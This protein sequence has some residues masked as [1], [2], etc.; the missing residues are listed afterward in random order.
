MLTLAAPWWLALVV[1]P[2]VLERVLPAY[3]QPRRAV[4]VPF[5]D[6]LAA[7]TG[8][9]PSRGAA[10][11]EGPT[12]QRLVLWLVW[13]LIVAALA[14]PQRLEPPLTRTVP[15]RDL[16]LAVDLS[17]SMETRDFT[18]ATGARIDRLTAVKTVLDDFLTRRTGDRVGLIVFGSAPFVQVPFTDDLTTCRAL[19]D[20]VQ[21]RMAGPQTA[22]GDAIGLALD[23]FA[24]ADGPRDRVLIALTDGNDTGSAVPPVRAAE[25]AHDRGVVV[26]TVAVGDPTAAGE[27]A[28]DEATLQA[29]ATTTGGRYARANDRDALARV[30]AELDALGTRP[31]ETVSHQPRR[32]LFQW[33]LGAALV[34]V[35]AYHGAWIVRRGVR[36]RAA[37]PAALAALP[38]GTFHFLRPWWLLALVPTVAVFMAVRSLLDETRPWRG[39]IAPHLL[40]HL[41]TGRDERRGVQPAH[42]LL[43]GGVLM[44]LAVAGPAWRLEPSPFGDDAA[45]IV[46]VLE[47]TP[48]M[49]GTD[50]QPT[51]LARAAQKVRD[52]LAARPGTRAGLVAYAGSG[53]LVLPP[54]SDASLVGRFAD[55]LAPDLMPVDGDVP[56]DGLAVAQA[57]LVRAGVPG[58]IVLVT[59]GIPT[60]DE[61]RLTAWH[62]QGSAPV[63]VLAVAAGA[64]AAALERGAAT[65]G[66]DVTVVTP[67]DADVRQLARRAQARVVAAPGTAGEGARWQDAGWWLAFGVAAIALA[68]FRPGWVVAWR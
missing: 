9:T 47:V 19:L 41:L 17:G 12:V 65:L 54:T 67:D 32:D 25:I 52:L 4:V 66:A 28:L 15:T 56:S 29:V 40:S 34:L 33:P 8:A 20:E 50:V 45:A 1:L 61:A 43:A 55:E 38:F 2:L 31:V 16:L 37:A 23:V 42:L 7:L 6:R 35:L 44:T 24:R 27:Q 48:T 36:V 30:Y 58:S 39:V 26:H 21:V 13:L 60:D 14:R 46:V 63:Q 10:V 57:E 3:R 5:L 51:R 64:E 59:D 53:H 18:D 49:L 68:W 11:A 22:F 62:A